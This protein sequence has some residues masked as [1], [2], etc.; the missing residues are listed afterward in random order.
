MTPPP[1]TGTGQQY[2]TPYPVAQ[3]SNLPL[4]LGV[5]GVVVVLALAA[6]VLLP[7]LSPQE[8]PVTLV[9]ATLPAPT[10][11]QNAHRVQVSQNSVNIPREWI[12][13]QGFYDLSDSER[14]VHLW[15]PQD[16][17]SFV[18]VHIPT[19]I[20]ITDPVDF[21]TGIQDYSERWYGENRAD[22]LSLI[23][24]DTAPDGT[25]RQSYRVF[26]ETSPQLEPGQIDVFYLNRAPYLVVFETYSA[27][28]L[29]N[30]F[31]PTFQRIL[32]SLNVKTGT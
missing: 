31:V 20:T 1:I 32:D 7:R 8:V 26:G 14:L 3:R 22:N 11:I 6:V 28:A 13:P 5:V 10:P 27:D 25:V 4:I 23:D 9:Q 29:G 12:P 15:Q 16:L 18:A 24:T 21:E 2:P 30:R 17:S 19:T